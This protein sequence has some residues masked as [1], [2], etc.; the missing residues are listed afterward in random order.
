VGHSF[1]EPIVPYD[2]A[3]YAQVAE[4]LDMRIA[5]G[6]N[7]YTKYAFADLIASLTQLSAHAA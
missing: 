6:E 3:G 5:T 4:A 2:H 1:E 7:D